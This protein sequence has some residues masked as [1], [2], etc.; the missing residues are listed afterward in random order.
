MIASRHRDIGR[1]LCRLGRGRGLGPLRCWHHDTVLTAHAHAHGWLPTADSDSSLR[2]GR[3]GRVAPRLDSPR[4]AS[5]V[6]WCVLA[7]GWGCDCLLRVAYARRKTQDACRSL[8]LSHT[9]HLPESPFSLSHSHSRSRFAPPLVLI[10]ALTYTLAHLH[11]F[12]L[13]H[14][15]VQCRLQTSGSDSSHPTHTLH[16]RRDERTR[17]IPAGTSQVPVVPVVLL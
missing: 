2:R 12:A 6:I 8:L 7:R 15:S 13:P 1:D 9:S 4:L 5:P 17:Q 10:I 14:L 3:G 16:A 11:A